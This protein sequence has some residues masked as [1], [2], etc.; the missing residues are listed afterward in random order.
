[1]EIDSRTNDDRWYV[2]DAVLD[3]LYWKDV[4]IFTTVARKLGTS[5]PQGQSFCRESRT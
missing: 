4:S 1:M 5:C 3:A 2:T